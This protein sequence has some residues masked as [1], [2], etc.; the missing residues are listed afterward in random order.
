MVFRPCN[1]HGKK[2]CSTCARKKV[3]KY[4]MH[5]VKVNKQPVCDPLRPHLSADPEPPCRNLL[6]IYLQVI[7]KGVW[8]Y[9]LCGLAIHTLGCL[10]WFF[11]VIPPSVAPIP[12]F[13][14]GQIVFIIGFLIFAY[15]SYGNNRF[16]DGV[17]NYEDLLNAVTSLSEDF[18]GA[19]RTWK[20]RPNRN[21]KNIID[22]LYVGFHFNRVLAYATKWAFRQEVEIDRLPLP[23]DLKAELHR[24]EHDPI[25]HMVM[26]INGAA[27]RLQDELVF[28]G[29]MQSRISNNLGAF[30]NSKGGIEKSRIFNEPFIYKY[31]RIFIVSVY[32]AFMFVLHLYPFY[33]WWSYGFVVYF[34]WGVFG[35]F[36]ASE[37]LQNPFVDTDFQEFV[38]YNIGKQTD[39]AAQTIIGNWRTKLEEAGLGIVWTDNGKLGL[40]IDGGSSSTSSSATKCA[41]KSSA[42]GTKSG[43]KSVSSAIKWQGASTMEVHRKSPHST[44]YQ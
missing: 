13:W 30:N 41:L 17:S 22:S 36:A 28:S 10:L 24:S 9:M 39:G 32:V 38:D 7:W 5:S 23:E 6:A 3:R 29:P 19:L 16:T 21:N 18:C 15:F 12:E 31:H 1:K 43:E 8:F 44:L 25:S 20:I 37:Y 27:A 2:D 35:L 42:K 40:M 26:Q 33:G 4:K 14:I 11:G 34:I